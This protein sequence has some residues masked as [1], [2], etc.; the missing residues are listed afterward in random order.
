MSI[1]TIL[2]LIS[3]FALILLSGF[4]SG[5][6][7]ALTAT[8]KPRILLKI[9]KGNKRAKFVLK[10]LDNIENVIS[11]LL[12]SNNLVNILASSLATAVLYDLFGVSGIFY[13]TL[14]MTIL[15]VV[16]AEILPKTYSLNRPTR[17]SLII[18]PIIFYLSKFLYP[19]IFL[20]NL[21]VKKIFLKKTSNDSK[22]KDQQSEEELQGVIDMYKTSNPDSEH[23]KDMLQ[24]ILML[25]DTTVEEVFT[26]RKNIYSIDGSLDISEIITKINQSRFT[27]IPVWKSNPENIVGLLN[28]RTLNID[29][30]NQESSKEII[31]DKISKPWF[32]PETTNLLEQLVAFKKKKEHIAFVVDEYGEL[33]GLITL[34]DIIEEIVGEIVDEIDVPDEEFSKNNEGLI[35]TNGEK[36]LKD[37][38]KHFD[39]DLPSSE[40]STISGHILEIAKRIPLFGETVKDNHFIYKILSHSRKQISKIEIT[41]IK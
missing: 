20:I 40:A 10:I 33:L 27:R 17:T 19:I 41:Q 15:I 1:I 2:L 26:H 8:S 18:A 34:E 37:L 7:T 14:I 5:S 39:L 3:L 11:S 16:F 23:E 12:L 9:K 30:S 4:L 29:L 24:S 6:E 38:Y 28:V 25:N 32:I 21:I 35:I 13:A 36:N 31:F 22:F